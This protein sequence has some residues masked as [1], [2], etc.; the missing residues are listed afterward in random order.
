MLIVTLSI[1]PK[2]WNQSECPSVLK[3]TMKMRSYWQLMMAAVESVFFRDCDQEAVPAPT[4][5]HR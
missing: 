2:I 1:I 5:M 3:W 4:P